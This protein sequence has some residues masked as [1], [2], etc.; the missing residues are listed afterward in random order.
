MNKTEYVMS[1]AVIKISVYCIVIVQ[2]MKLNW[3][4]MFLFDS[5]LSTGQADGQEETT[6]GGDQVGGGGPKKTG[7]VTKK[8]TGGTT[9][10]RDT[11]SN[12][13][14]DFQVGSCVIKSSPS[15]NIRIIIRRQQCHVL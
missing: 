15:I 8:T 12:K 6:D 10:A 5:F 3:L 14:Q 7:T 4:W 1:L 2:K 11:L 9:K 13:P